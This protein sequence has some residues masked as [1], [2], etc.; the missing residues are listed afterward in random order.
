ML[1][2]IS[3]KTSKPTAAIIASQHQEPLP[4]YDDNLEE[5]SIVSALEEAAE[6]DPWHAVN[7]WRVSQLSSHSSHHNHDDDVSSKRSSSDMLGSRTTSFS[8]IRNQAQNI[9]SEYLSE[10]LSAVV[11]RESSV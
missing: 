10:L 8:S 11:D 5:I 4:G 6:D 1:E 2:M 3:Q 9:P 7:Q